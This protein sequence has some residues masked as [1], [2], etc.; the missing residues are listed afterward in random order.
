MYKPTEELLY[1]AK[2]ILKDGYY[3][4]LRITINKTY[5][6]IGCGTEQYIRASETKDKQV[7]HCR[8]KCDKCRDCYMAVAKDILSKYHPKIKV[9]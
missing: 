4:K 5:G 1:V 2:S 7:I 9:V 8:E 6:G 3:S